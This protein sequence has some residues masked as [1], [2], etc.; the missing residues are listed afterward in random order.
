MHNTVTAHWIAQDEVY[1]AGQLLLLQMLIFHE[2]VPCRLWHSRISPPAVII[3]ALL[4]NVAGR[5]PIL[6]NNATLLSVGSL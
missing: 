4:A 5:A 2:G 1:S 3:Y 6:E